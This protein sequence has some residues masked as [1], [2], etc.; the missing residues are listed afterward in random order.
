MFWRLLFFFLI[1][2]F[3][4]RAVGK[5]LQSEKPKHEVRGQPKNPNS[6]DLSD[7]DIEEVDFKEIKD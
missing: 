4:I 5:L 3:G 1:I 7:K 2:Y 6:I